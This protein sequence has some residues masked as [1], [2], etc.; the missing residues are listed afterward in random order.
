MLFRSPDD[1]F[2][3][4]TGASRADVKDYEDSI[5]GLAE[6]LPLIQKKR[7]DLTFWGSVH[8]DCLNK[9]G[10]IP[11]FQYLEEKKIRIAVC[12]SSNSEYV[13]TLIHTVSAPL[14]VDVMVTGEMVEHSKPDPEVFLKAAEQ[15]NIKPEECLVLED[16]K[17][18]II[19]AWRAGMHS[20]FIYDT[21]R[22]DAE[23]KQAIEF[24]EPSMNEVIEL[25]EHIAEQAK[26]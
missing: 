11:L 7:F 14:H 26:D 10:L 9:K 12:S 18:G 5:P 24:Q 19:A 4:I 22:P 1:F 8:T 23:M 20:C 17:Q 3:K 21:I 2:L 16:S 15:L 6:V 25:L 13:T